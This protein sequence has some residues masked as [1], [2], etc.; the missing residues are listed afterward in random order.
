MRFKEKN[1]KPFKFDMCIWH[2][3]ILISALQ[4]FA[5]QYTICVLVASSVNR[6]IQRIELWGKFTIGKE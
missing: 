3:H 1:S 2:D 5:I 4:R 6:S